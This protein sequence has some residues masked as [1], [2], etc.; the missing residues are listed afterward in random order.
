MR[1]ALDDLGAQDMQ[2][3]SANRRVLLLVV[4][5]LLVG[6]LA[7]VNM[8]PKRAYE[9]RIAIPITDKKIGASTPLLCFYKTGLSAT[10]EGKRS[11]RKVDV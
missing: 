3:R 1:A 7:L 4:A 11:R 5:G 9:D 2:Q 10:V 8:L 6:A